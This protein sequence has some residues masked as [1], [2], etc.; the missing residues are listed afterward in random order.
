MEQTK[1]DKGEFRAIAKAVQSKIDA[2][3]SKVSEFRKKIYFLYPTKVYSDLFY[4]FWDYQNFLYKK[5]VLNTIR[6][7]GN[8]H[9]FIGYVFDFKEKGSVYGEKFQI[10]TYWDIFTLNLLDMG[11][12][13]PYMIENQN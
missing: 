7:Y 13:E 1:M 2:R 5:Q 12:L 11:L 4:E 3:D 8:F 9:E 10:D 6:K